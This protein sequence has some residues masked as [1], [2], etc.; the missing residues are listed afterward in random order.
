LHTALRRL[1]HGT[2]AI[3]S[4]TGLG[5]GLGCTPW[6]VPATAP[7]QCGI[8]WAHDLWAEPA[9][10]RVVLEAP[11]RSWPPPP[12]LPGRRGGAAALRALTFYYASPSLRRLAAVLFHACR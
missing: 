1:P 12:W 6:G 5:Y 9:L 7:W 8:G 2:V 10:Q 11:F 3:N 4:W